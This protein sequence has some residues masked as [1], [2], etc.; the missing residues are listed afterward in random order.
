VSGDFDEEVRAQLDAQGPIFGLQILFSDF[1]QQHSAASPAPI[2][3]LQTGLH[4]GELRAATLL[5]LHS[6][7]D[8]AVCQSGG[9]LQRPTSRCRR[10]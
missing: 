5:A 6:V 8:N 1:H 10:S 4:Q 9:G 3:S 7:N 2:R